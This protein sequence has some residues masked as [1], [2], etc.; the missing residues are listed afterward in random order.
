MV[1]IYIGR[2]SKTNLFTGS[3]A[4]DVRLYNDDEF[5]VLM[6]LRFPAYNRIRQVDSKDFPGFMYLDFSNACLDNMV[7]NTLTNDSKFMRQSCLK[8]WLDHTFKSALQNYGNVVDTDYDRYTLKYIWRGITYTIYA[9]SAS[10]SF[11][12][13][14]VPAVKIVRNSHNSKTWYAI[15]KQSVGPGHSSSFTFMLSNSQ[16][17]LHHVSRC[18]QTMRD[19]LRLLQAL[20]NSKIFQSCAATIWSQWLFGWLDG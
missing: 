5:D 11:S 10:R 4:H 15:P 20:R 14:F 8:S 7:D 18:G 3:V 2:L 1:D 9:K 13:D 16:G 19:A 12:I 17:E 6:E